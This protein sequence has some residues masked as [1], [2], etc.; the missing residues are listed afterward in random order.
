MRF[1][2]SLLLA[3]LALVLLYGNVWAD[4]Y[5]RV[6]PDGSVEFSDVPNSVG[7]KPIELPPD[8]SYTPPTPPKPAPVEARKKVGPVDYQSVSITSPANE[9]TIRDNEGKISIVIGSKPALQADHS[10]VLM[11]DGK[12]VGSGSNKTF[13]L[14]NIDRGT[15][16]F[17]CQIIDKKQRMLIQ[18]QPVKLH[19]IRASVR[20]SS[21]KKR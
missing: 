8:S 4:V 2:F 7:A 13:Q 15:H 18:S 5:K 1:R 12:K 9:A 11:M 16:T 20:R 14:T 21:G 10:Y 3:T 17:T 6:N 19:L